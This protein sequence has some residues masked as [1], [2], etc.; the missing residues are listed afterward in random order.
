MEC[1]IFIII[2]NVNEF[3]TIGHNHR[4]TCDVSQDQKE[5]DRRAH[6]ECQADQSTH[7][8]FDERLR[9]DHGR[10]RKKHTSRQV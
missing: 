10:S 5:G 6:D 3:E 8:S 4:T 2:S 1:L 9:G 7:R